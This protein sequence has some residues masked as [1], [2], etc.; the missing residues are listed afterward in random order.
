MRRIVDVDFADEDLE[1]KIEVFALK[2]G[3]DLEKQAIGN[4]LLIKYTRFDGK[5]FF[6]R[7]TL[8]ESLDRIK[9]AGV[10]NRENANTLQTLQ[11]LKGEFG[12]IVVNT[13]NYQKLEGQDVDAKLVVVAARGQD[14]SQ[15]W[16]DLLVVGREINN[17]KIDYEPLL[18]NSNSFV[19]TALN[20]TNVITRDE[21]L[22][23]LKEKQ[24]W[25]PAV[26]TKLSLPNEE[27]Y[28]ANTAQ[29]DRTDSLNLEE[30]T[31]SFEKRS[32]FSSLLNSKAST[33]IEP[34]ELIDSA[35]SKEIERDKTNP[36]SNNSPTPENEKWAKNILPT[37]HKA[38]LSAKYSAR[39][40]IKER[41][42][43]IA[44][45]G[46]YEIEINQKERIVKVRNEKDKRDVVSYNF[47]DRDKPVTTAEPKEE[48]FKYW[49]EEQKTSNIINKNSRKKNKQKTRD[50]QL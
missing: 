8:Q 29:S 3:Q 14:L 2:L 13:G 27:L 24:I 41:G 35:N 30:P 46:S 48:D 26:K 49:Q 47:A 21:L 17:A 19:A 43:G 16:R 31:K 42:I 25:S 12:K 50:I 10:D 4:S 18:A 11:D 1:E 5:E 33:K 45:S 28:T 39:I 40:E 32:L 36:S 7:G 9:L 37:I 38:I 34:S 15:Q 22:Q 44:K 6:L 20:R 23:Q